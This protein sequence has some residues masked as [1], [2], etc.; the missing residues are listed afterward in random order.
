MLGPAR[1]K[2][3]AEDEGKN[4]QHQQRAEENPQHAEHRP[5]VAQQHVPFDQLAEQVAVAPDVG[6]DLQGV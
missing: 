5:P 3:L 2:N 1:L 6:K 4:C